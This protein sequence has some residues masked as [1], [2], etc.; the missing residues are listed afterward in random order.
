MMQISSVRRLTGLCGL[1]G[2]RVFF[3]GDMLFYGHFGSGAYF[4]AGLINTV[5]HVSDARL[6]AGGLVGPFAA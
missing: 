6:Y 3:P 5:T 1:A 4:S 2:A